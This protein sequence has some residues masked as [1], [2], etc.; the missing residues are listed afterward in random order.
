MVWKG[1]PMS[2]PRC[3]LFLR[4]RSS[5]IT[6]HKPAWDWLTEQPLCHD[7]HGAVRLAE[8]QVP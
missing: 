6:D 8:Q 2:F 1:K 4:S 3:P 7:H 5:G